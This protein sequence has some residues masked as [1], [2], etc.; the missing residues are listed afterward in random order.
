MMTSIGRFALSVLIVAAVLTVAIGFHGIRRAHSREAYPGQ[1]AQY[2]PET[3]R[4]F[5]NQVSP[6]GARCCDISDGEFAEEDIHDGHYWTRWSAHPD[7]MQVPDEVVIK[8]PNKWGKATVW[9]GKSVANDG[10]SI[11]IIRCYAVGAK[12]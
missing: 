2:D 11:F 6:Q 5:N 4:W 1:Y 8:T 10:S 9:W 12:S 3:R 7:W